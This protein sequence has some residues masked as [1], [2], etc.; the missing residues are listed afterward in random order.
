MRTSSYLDEVVVDRPKVVD[1]SFQR[2]GIYKWRHILELAEG[3][4]KKSIMAMRCS[5][6]RSNSK[7]LFL[8]SE[9]REFLRRTTRRG[10]SC[11]LS[12]IYV[13]LTADV[14]K[15]LA[16]HNAGQSPQTSK[17]KPWTLVVAWSPRASNWPTGV[18][19]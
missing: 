17:L 19:K 13:G 5:R 4:P 3:D 9:F 12:L 8:S 1:R 7:S 10:I 2:L 18:E 11:N 15:R 16:W 14:S 6:V